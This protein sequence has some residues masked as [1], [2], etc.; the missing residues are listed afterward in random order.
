VRVIA[1]KKETLQALSVPNNIVWN[2]LTFRGKETDEPVD[3]GGDT[4]VDQRIL[5]GQFGIAFCC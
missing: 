2:L 1:T 4:L 5:L 3:R